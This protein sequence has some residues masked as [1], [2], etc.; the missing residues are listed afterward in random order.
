MKP[1][2]FGT[3]E[4]T[5]LR[6]SQTSELTKATHQVLHGDGGGCKASLPGCVPTRS[7]DRQL[8]HQCTKRTSPLTDISTLHA[9]TMIW[10]SAV[11]IRCLRNGELGCVRRK[12]LKQRR[13]AWVQ[14]LR[15]MAVQVGSLKAQWEGRENG[16]GGVEQAVGV[17]HRGIYIQ[18]A[19]SMWVLRGTP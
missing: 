9:A 17:N 18:K 6:F 4:Q 7:E 12:I 16:A 19:D 11:L 15:R 14:P 2:S 3:K 8:W 10:W 5:S 13:N 1:L